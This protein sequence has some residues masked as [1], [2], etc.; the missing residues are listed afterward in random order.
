MIRLPDKNIDTDILENCGGVRSYEY[1]YVLYN[2]V[3]VIK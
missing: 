2:R 1:N 3:W